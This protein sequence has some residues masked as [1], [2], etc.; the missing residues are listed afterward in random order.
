MVD[1]EKVDEK[2][3]QIWTQITNSTTKELYQWFRLLGIKE[4]YQ[5][6]F[7]SSVPQFFIKIKNLI[8]FFQFN[9][10]WHF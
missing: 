5:M 8:N 3:T 9:A 6:I 1:R 10:K 2:E 7:S 4:L